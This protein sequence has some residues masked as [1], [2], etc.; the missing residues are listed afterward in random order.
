MRA[1]THWVEDLVD[2]L[3]RSRHGSAAAAV[4]VANG[5]QY[6]RWLL[7]A[8]WLLNVAD[9]L[10]TRD[11]LAR[12]MAQEAN[13]VMGFFI[14]TGPLAAAAFKVGVVTAGVISLWLLRRH[15]I[16]LRAT[17]LVTGFYGAVVAYELVHL[18]GLA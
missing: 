18:L 16:V 7:A 11:A 14:S 6:L 15:R 2:T 1:G 4:P 8:L 9:L 17:V 5:A 13:Q 12:G 10:L 3:H